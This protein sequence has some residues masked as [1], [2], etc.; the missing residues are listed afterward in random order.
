MKHDRSNIHL[1]KRVSALLLA[2]VFVFLSLPLQG[3]RVL[4]GPTGETTT[5]G[6]YGSIKNQ[7]EKD[8]EKATIDKKV[9][10]GEN[11]GEHIIDLVITGKDKRTIDSIDVVIVYDN[12]NS[13]DKEID[14]NGTATTR[15]AAAAEA[16][17]EFI[18]ELFSM[19]NH[20]FKVALVTYGTMVFDGVTANEVYSWNDQFPGLVEN[21]SHL[22]PTNSATTIT[23]KIPT[24][25]PSARFV[26]GKYLVG[27]GGTF[28][29]QAL[30][31]P[32]AQITEFLLLIQHK[33]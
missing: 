26:N 24:N 20:K 16:T 23:N 2:L 27:N 1:H 6:L 18:D 28:T 19:P 4:G 10:F 3:L 15:V 13:M 7:S 33:A 32:A 5:E 14:E 8:F 9:S 12:S 21:Y 22:T 31:S 29:Q 17:A 25:V 30:Q 11:P